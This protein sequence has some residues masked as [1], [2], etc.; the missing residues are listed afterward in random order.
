MPSKPTDAGDGE[1]IWGSRGRLLSAPPGKAP[2]P[3]AFA[4]QHAVTLANALATLHRQ[5]RTDGVV[6]PDET[7][8][9]A[10]RADMAAFGE[11]LYLMLTG[12]KA[13]AGLSSDAEP[14]SAESQSDEIRASAIR[15]AIRCFTGGPD[16]MPDMHRAATEVRLLSLMARQRDPASAS[17]LLPRPTPESAKRDAVAGELRPARFLMPPEQ[18]AQSPTQSAVRCP[19]CGHRYVYDSR[20]ATPFEKVLVAIGFHVRRCRRCWHRYVAILGMEFKLS[21]R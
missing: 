12:T 6:G 15:L 16:A 21:G 14:S 10:A 20:P 19:K 7:H 4:L 13:P 8:E 1:P 3:L 9:D 17:L 2:L 18:V 11:L 5:G